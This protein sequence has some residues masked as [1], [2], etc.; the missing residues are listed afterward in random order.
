MIRPFGLRNSLRLQRLV[1][2]STPLSLEHYFADADAAFWAAVGSPLPWHG[3]GAATYLHFPASGEPPIPAFIQAVKRFVRPEADLTRIAP[4]HDA[5]P[6][7]PSLWKRLLEHLS[8]SAGEHGIHRLYL[9]LESNDDALATVAAAG[10]AAYIQETLFRHSG[11]SLPPPGNENDWPHVRPQRE[12]DSFAL[13]RLHNR[14]TPLLV[15]QAEGGLSNSDENPS[16][17]DL[18]TWWQPE[19]TE[20]FV[21]EDKGD[22]LA[23]V[24]LIRGGNIHW[25]HLLGD[26]ASPEPISE[27][28]AR[29]LHALAHYSQRPILC[30]LRPYQSSFGPH[31]RD[32]AFEPTL[33]VTRFVKHTTS[34]ARR[35]AP[36]PSKE[37]AEAVLAGLLSAELP[38]RSPG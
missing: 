30:P 24:Q 38:R 27:L 17:F 26:P 35:T 15:Q 16:P 2:R 32:R 7:A 21:Y 33:T 37:L 6:Q 3:V 28:L 14:H 9:C 36:V 22:V 11:I 19:R 29:S 10:F 12:I 20:G 18:R 23:A 8:Y 13:Q 31:L 34:L 1:Q 4:A 5:S 25:L